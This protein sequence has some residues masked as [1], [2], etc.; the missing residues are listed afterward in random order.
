[1][2]KIEFFFFFEYCKYFIEIK[3]IVKHKECSKTTR[4]KYNSPETGP[5]K[6]NE[7]DR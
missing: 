3:V 6:E 4:V 5:A 1:L 2:D 7:P